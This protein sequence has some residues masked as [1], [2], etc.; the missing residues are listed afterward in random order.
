MERVKDELRTEILN[1]GNNQIRAA[2]AEISPVQR[3]LEQ[4]SVHDRA[5]HR[6]AGGVREVREGRRRSMTATKPTKPLKLVFETE[7]DGKPAKLAVLPPS[8]AIKGD[9][10]LVHAKAYNQ[11]VRAG[12]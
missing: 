6:R 4:V 5:R 7:I 11:A 10:R 12:R 3:E 1:L 8:A 9:G 2:A